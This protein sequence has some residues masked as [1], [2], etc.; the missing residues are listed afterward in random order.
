MIKKRMS[1]LDGVMISK[2]WES[3]YL[4]LA[5]HYPLYSGEYL[6]IKGEL[7]AHVDMFTLVIDFKEYSGEPLE[8]IEEGV[9]N[10]ER[11]YGIHI[12]QD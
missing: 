12:I 10:F 2:L 9:K 7:G 6:R 3:I 11:D 5:K 4:V 8:I 1:E